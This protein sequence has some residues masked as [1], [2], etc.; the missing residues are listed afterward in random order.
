T[1]YDGWAGNGGPGNGGHDMGGGNGDYGSGN[2]GGSSGS[3]DPNAPSTPDPCGQMKDLKN[4]SEYA[5]Y[6]RYL[7][8]KTGNTSESGFRV[9]DPV[10][11]S[12]QVGTQ[13]QELSN[14][15]GDGNGSLDFS[16]FGTTYGIMHSHYDTLISIF[17]PDDVNLFIQLLKNAKANGIPVNKVF[18]SVVTS[19][20][21][22]QLRG[23]NID[24]D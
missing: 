9:G 14:K 10:K 3:S 8:T 13:F 24:P 1:M 6:T 4:K 21:I 15:P 2:G 20:G 12:N 18:I 17:S 16:I 23:D 19:D 22:Y 7:E 5:K 11:G